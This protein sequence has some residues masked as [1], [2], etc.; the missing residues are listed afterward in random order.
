MRSS[1]ASP[2]G[3]RWFDSATTA[4]RNVAIHES[5]PSAPPGTWSRR[6]S[7][8]RSGLNGRASRPRKPQAT[9][10]RGPPPSR[11]AVVTASPLRLIENGS[12]GGRG[13]K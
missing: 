7:D 11:R 8:A 1:T 3:R 13:A 4:R 12:W 2:P 5:G 9:V 6:G 10:A